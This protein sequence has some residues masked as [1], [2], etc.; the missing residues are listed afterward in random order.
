MLNTILL[1]YQSVHTASNEGPLM[2]I[3]KILVLLSLI[4]K[5]GKERKSIYIAPF[6]YT[7]RK[8]LRHGSHSFTCKYTMPAFLSLHSLEVATS[9]RYSSR[10]PV[11]AAYSFIDPEGMKG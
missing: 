6:Y 11:A 2:Q 10:R 4:G 9:T 8:A 5:E 1:V 3:T 7:V